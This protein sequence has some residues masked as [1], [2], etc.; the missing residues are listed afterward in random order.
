MPK[1]KSITVIA[2]KG[3]N[4]YQNANLTKKAKN[5]KKGTHLKVKKIVRHNLTSRYQLSNGDY[6]TGNKKL[7]IQGNH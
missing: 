4:A 7:V 6:I 1:D 2:K 3:V 5:Y